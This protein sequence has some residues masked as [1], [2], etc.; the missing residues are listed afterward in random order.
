LAII[1]HFGVFLGVLAPPGPFAAGVLHQPL[2]VGPC[3]PAGGSPPGEGSGP[4]RALEPQPTPLGVSARPATNSYRYTRDFYGE[5]KLKS[6]RNL[7]TPELLY[8]YYTPPSRGGPRA[9]PS[10]RPARHGPPTRRG[11]P[12]R[13][14]PP[15]GVD[16]KQPPGGRPPGRRGPPEGPGGLPRGPRGP[17]PEDLGSRSRR[18]RRPSP[19]GGLEARVRVPDTAAYGVLHQPLAAGPCPRPAG[20]R[21][22]GVPEDSRRPPL[23]AGPDHPARTGPD[24][25]RDF[26][27]QGPAARG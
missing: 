2:A 14:A 7:T 15:R 21:R 12:G 1:P 27:G 20:S 16:V 3:G 13:R 19:G 11:G 25:P 5:R 24:T 26:R 10:G 9:V 6:Q 4:L 18:G 23:E 17:D 22:P 8:T